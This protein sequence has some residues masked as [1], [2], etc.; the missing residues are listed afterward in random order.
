VTGKRPPAPRKEAQRPPRIPEPHVIAN[1]LQALLKRESPYG[2]T[3]KGLS[4]WRMAL[5]S[6]KAKALAPPTTG[7]AAFVDR[8]LPGLPGLLKAVDAHI[9]II[10]QIENLSG[11]GGNPSKSAAAGRFTPHSLSVTPPLSRLLKLPG[12]TSPTSPPARDVLPPLRETLT[13]A[14][15]ASILRSTTGM[16]DLL[17]GETHRSTAANATFLQASISNYK[18]AGLPI[19]PDLLTL[20]E[21]HIERQLMEAKLQRA[22]A[23]GDFSTANQLMTEIGEVPCSPPPIS[24]S[25]AADLDVVCD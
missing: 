21:E 3:V 12:A 13:P 18:S 16:D 17:S 8:G 24:G 7:G 10:Q 5:S 4:R 14:S 23:Q 20:A 19:F 22:V 1:Y 15:H 25:M 9:D 6:A 11:K 2:G